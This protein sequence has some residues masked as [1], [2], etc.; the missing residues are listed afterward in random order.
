MT[1]M[2]DCNRVDWLCSADHR[3]NMN[4]LLALFY[5]PMAQW[6]RA[7]VAARSLAAGGKSVCSSG[8]LRA[9]AV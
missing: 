4:N 2:T 3:L 8:P 9:P 5:D 6:L 1:S 7:C